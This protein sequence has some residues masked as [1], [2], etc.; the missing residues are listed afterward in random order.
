[1]KM[2]KNDWILIFVIVCAAA[3][4]LLLYTKFGRQNAGEVVVK[5]DGE[6]RNTYSLSGNM[7]VR[8]SDTNVFA[9][10]DGEVKMLEANCPDQIC[11][12]HKAISKNKE[13]IICLP[14]KVVVEVVSGH[15]A[16]LDII[17]N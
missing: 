13:T 11:V 3:A 4:C 5:V 17:A 7:E 1:M 6:V 10:K 9:I 12:H 8:I 2:K 14:N 15:Q 16:D